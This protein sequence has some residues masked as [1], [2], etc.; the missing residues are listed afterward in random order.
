MAVPDGVLPTLIP[1]GSMAG[2]LASAV[3]EDPETMAL[4]CPVVLP[5]GAVKPATGLDTLSRTNSAARSSAS[6]CVSRISR[7][8]SNDR[9]RVTQLPSVIFWSW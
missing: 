6:M 4:A 9:I 1:A 5:S 2:F 7:V 3:P 8:A